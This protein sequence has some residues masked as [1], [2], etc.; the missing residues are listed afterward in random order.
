MPHTAATWTLRGRF[1]WICVRFV[2]ALQTAEMLL[3]H[4]II[5][6]VWAGDGR[7]KAAG[8]GAPRPPWTALRLR[9]IQL[10]DVNV[11]R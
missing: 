3:G 5:C 2:T 10:L 1:H 4:F 9:P 6:Q 7:P 11:K 8:G